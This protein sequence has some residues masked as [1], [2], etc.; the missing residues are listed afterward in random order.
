MAGSFLLAAAPPPSPRAAEVE[1]FIAQLGSDAFAERE[2][3]S[4]RL[5]AIGEPALEA[6][7]KALTSDDLEVRDRARR[8][9]AV[10]ENRI[11]AEQL[12]LTGHAGALWAVCVSADGKR[13]L[14]SGGDR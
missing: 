3:A 2:A 13:L 14:T 7:R 6:L 10:V 4:K 9:V 12:R 11:Y 1:R 5:E 8:V